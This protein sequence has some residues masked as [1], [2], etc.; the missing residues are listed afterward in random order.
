MENKILH[1]LRIG[2]IEKAFARLYR[3]FGK[4]E[5]YILQNSGTKDEALDI[6]QDGLVLLYKKV[7]SSEWDETSHVEGFLV[8]SCK[9]LWQNELRKKKV[10]NNTDYDSFNG[11]E[12]LTDELEYEAKLKTIEKVLTRIG[13]KCKD[14]LT[15]FYLHRLKMPD[16]AKMFGFK[17]VQSAKVQKYK[18][19]EN[20]RKLVGEFKIVEG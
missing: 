13:K 5:A 2:K 19:M 8:Q 16:I 14:I 4:V 7:N 6:F 1:L 20:A 10:R 15:Q 12:N 11:G 3:N 18:C 9:L 17:T